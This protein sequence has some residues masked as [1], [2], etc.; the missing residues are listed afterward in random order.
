MSLIKPQ[1]TLGLV[2]EYNPFHNGHAYHLKASLELSK[3]EVT[4]AIM[5]GYFTQRGEPAIADPFT[6]AKWAVE[7][8]VDLV[9]MLPVIFSTA[10]APMFAFGAL[11]CLEALGNVDA[12]CF[13][14]ESGDLAQLKA[15]TAHLTDMQDELN[16]LT[17]VNSEQTYNALRDQLLLDRGYIGPSSANDILGLAYL[18]GLHQLNSRIE[19]LTIKRIENDYHSKDLNTEIA[20][21]TAVRAGFKAGGSKAVSHTL[22]K[23][24]LESFEAADFTSP[25]DALWHKLQVYELRRSRVEDLEQIHDMPV[26]MAQR[27]K[28]AAAATH[29]L[30]EF[31][32]AIQTKAYTNSRLQR[33]LAKMMLGIT[34]ADLLNDFGTSPSYLRILAFNNKGRALLKNANP[35]L[36]LITNAK[37]FKPASALAQ[38]QWT[39]DCYAADVYNLLFEPVRAS[40]EQLRKTPLYLNK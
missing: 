13:G 17:K 36:P 32:K 8:G 28:A 19:P 2:T 24:S 10:S 5:S 20:S 6:R 30:E 26:G 7:A 25:S 31:H 39:L 18:H 29:S 37:H 40:G 15:L 22:P 12:L 33:I 14:S 11:A 34:K 1:K 4:V 21:A 27:L 35:T 38:R 9:L 16:R 23:T 3:A